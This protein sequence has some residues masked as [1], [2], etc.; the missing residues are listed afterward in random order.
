MMAEGRQP[1][2]VAYR[3][4]PS[5]RTL[6][7]VVAGANAACYPYGHLPL[8]LAN[9]LSCFARLMDTLTGAGNLS[10]GTVRELATG[11]EGVNIAVRVDVDADLPTAVEM[12]RI[13]RE[14]GVPVSFYILHTASYYGQF[15]EGVF[16]RNECNAPLYLQLQQNGAEVGLHADPY[17]VYVDH[18]IDGAESVRAELEWLRGVGLHVRGTSAHNAAPVC[19]AENFEIFRGRAIRRGESFEHVGRTLPLGVLEERELGLEYEAGCARPA[20][21]PDPGRRAEYLAGLPPGDFLR[22]GR[23][24]RTYILDN[25]YCTWGFDYRVWLIGRDVWVFAGESRSGEKVFHFMVPWAEA[26]RALRA[27]GGD[28]TCQIVLHPLYL[29]KRARPDAWPIGSKSAFSGV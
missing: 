24:F 16:I 3:A 4:E 9:E 21:S 11:A 10:L 1:E 12:S 29:G 27:I 13:A 7:E 14:T 5:G 18:G 15:R 2:Y 17:G 8:E 28:E 19:G 6:E 23:W 26:E 25:P 22:D 20:D